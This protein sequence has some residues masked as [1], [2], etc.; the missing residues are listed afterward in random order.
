MED[1]TAAYSSAAQSLKGQK[2]SVA[3]ANSKRNK[4][5]DALMQGTAEVSLPKGALSF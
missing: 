4:N 2:G 1:N 5:A 3:S